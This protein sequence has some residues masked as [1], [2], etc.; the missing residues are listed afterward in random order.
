MFKVYLSNEIPKEFNE[1]YAFVVGSDGVYVY[2]KTNFYES[3]TK[4][5]KNEIPILNKPDQ[6]IYL[7]NNMNF[8]MY[9]MNI[10]YSF[11]ADVYE[12]YKSEAIVLIY[13]DNDQ[14]FY[15]APPLQ[16]VS[17]AHLDY[18]NNILHPNNMTLFGTIHSHGTMSAFHSGTDH[19]DEEFFDG[20]HI[21][22]G[23]ITSNPP[24]IS[25]SLVIDGFRGIIKEPERVIEKYGTYQKVPYPKE[26]MDQVKYNAPRQISTPT[27]YQIPNHF[28]DSWRWW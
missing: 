23:K 28:Y 14:K 24:D 16:K 13:I 26:W 19:K 9:L 27:H 25:I 12:K 4:S 20:L 22:L 15:I 21:T 2:R 8:P 3:L 7:R 18:K 17:G 6:F 10:T 11:F 1:K 5:K